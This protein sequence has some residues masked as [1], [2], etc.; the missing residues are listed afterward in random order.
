MIFKKEAKMIV[1][2]KMLKQIQDGLNDLLN[3]TNEMEKEIDAIESVLMSGAPK[4]AKKR[5]GR[6]AKRKVTRRK[7]SKSGSKKV[8]QIEKVLAAIP[9]SPDGVSI[10]EIYKKTGLERRAV[11]AVLNRAKKE[12]KVKNPKRGVY[13]KA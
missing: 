2:K 4:H 8:T 6:K 7:P 12:G 5:P 9:K 10:E 3:K 1:L 13:V 11:Y